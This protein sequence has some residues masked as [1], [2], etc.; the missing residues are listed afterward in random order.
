MLKLIIKNLAAAVVTAALLLPQI[1]VFAES[2]YLV[3]INFD[4]VSTN[5]Q[6]DAVVI[7]GS[8]NS[9]VV[10]DGAKNKSL[11]ADLSLIHI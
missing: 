7:D 3:N 1:P 9:R 10:E 11:M 2:D 4:D 5:G 8:S 6:T